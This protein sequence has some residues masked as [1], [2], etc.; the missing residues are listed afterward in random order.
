MIPGI[1]YPV[2]E[3]YEVPKKQPKDKV[4]WWI[5]TSREDQ[6]RCS[7]CDRVCFIAIYPWFGHAPYCP[8]CG[9]KMKGIKDNV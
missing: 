4:G 9:A 8:A 5:K 3:R 6:L 1:H 7:E 2:D